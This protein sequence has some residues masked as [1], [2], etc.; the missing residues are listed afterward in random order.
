MSRYW[1]CHSRALSHTMC[2]VNELLLKPFKSNAFVLKAMVKRGTHV[3][4]DGRDEEPGKL[5]VT[6]FSAKESPPRLRN[7]MCE[8]SEEFI[9][10]GVYK[11]YSEGYLRYSQA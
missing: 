1:H 10:R 3:L 9:S 4:T 8:F 7:F 5:H 6:T 11:A 2:C